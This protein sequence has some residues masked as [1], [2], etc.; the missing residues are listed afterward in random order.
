MKVNCHEKRIY[1]YH[2]AKI[3]SSFLSTYL[4]SSSLM[5]LGF[6]NVLLMRREQ[7][8][9][10]WIIICFDSVHIHFIHDHGQ[11]LSQLQ[12]HF[13]KHPSSSF[14]KTK[15]SVLLKW[16][17]IEP[18]VTVHQQNICLPNLSVRCFHLM[19]F[20]FIMLLL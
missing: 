14:A 8:H 2:F 4:L 13:L 19:L 6:C 5:S 12:I 15:K 16:K 3:L 1:P 10:I 7:V 18:F 17:G 20:P 9:G 11:W